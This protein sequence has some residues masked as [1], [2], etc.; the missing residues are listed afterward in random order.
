M[1][2][3]KC[4]GYNPTNHT[5]KAGGKSIYFHLARLCNCEV[6]CCS[7]KGYISSKRPAFKKN[8]SKSRCTQGFK[9]KT[10]FAAEWPVYVSAPDILAAT[11]VAGRSH[12]FTTLYIVGCF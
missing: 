3:Q 6:S 10:H 8:K 5:Q 11:A 4:I 2:L 7:C 1:Q 9:S 12:F